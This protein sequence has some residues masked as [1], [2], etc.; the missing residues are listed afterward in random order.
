MIANNIPN[1]SN[2]L[3]RVKGLIAYQDQLAKAKGET[4]NVFDILGLQTNEVR[5]HSAFIAELL[6]PAGSHMMETVFL[7][8]FLKRLNHQANFDTKSATAIVEYYIGPI[9]KDQTIGGRIDILLRDGTNQTIS[10]ENKI[11]AGDQDKQIVRYYNYKSDR[12]TVIYL[13]KFGDEPSE[14]SKGNLVK[15]KHYITISYQNDILDWLEDC[16]ALAYDQPIVRES[17]K[18]YKILIQ[19]ITH[20]LNNEEDKELNAL[21]MQHL[22]EASYISTKYHKVTNDLKQKFRKALLEELQSKIIDGD[23][24]LKGF[25][26]ESKKDI[27]QVH[28]AI[29]LEHDDSKVS[30]KWFGIES[31]SGKGNGNGVLYVGLFAGQGAN[32]SESDKEFDRLNIYWPHHRKLS[33][34]NQTIY[35]S[36]DSILKKMIKEDLLKKM[37]DGC[38]TQIIDF[39]KE[40]RR[41]IEA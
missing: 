16:Q 36:N 34:E 23:T 6:N 33:F 21:V 29:W 17:I 18:Q 37:V 27:T 39:I 40:N 7:D 28:A 38:T 1:Y 9:N 22:E 20:T 24:D 8:S 30:K 11:D 19:K 10:I 26:L 31:F 13:T 35:L 2:L 14:K 3:K 25:T 32:L 4:F 12:N 41:C 5:T 15:G